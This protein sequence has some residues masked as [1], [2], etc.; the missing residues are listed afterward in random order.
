MVSVHVSSSTLLAAADSSLETGD[1]HTFS[2]THAKQAL[3]FPQIL[4]FPTKW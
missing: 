4:D 3:F 2:Q 1:S